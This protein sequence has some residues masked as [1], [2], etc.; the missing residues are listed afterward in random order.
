MASGGR[1]ARKVQ[2]GM[3]THTVS[4]SDATPQPRKLALKLCTTSA[5]GHV[6]VTFNETSNQHWTGFAIEG[7]AIAAMMDKRTSR[8]QGS[9][10]TTQTGKS[11][12]TTCCL[13]SRGHLRWGGLR[14]RDAAIGSPRMAR[15]NV[16]KAAARHSR[17]IV[18]AWHSDFLALSCTCSLR[19]N[20]GKQKLKEP[21]QKALRPLPVNLVLG[22][23]F[24][25]IHNHPLLLHQCRHH[26]HLL[27]FANRG[28]RYSSAPQGREAEG[29]LPGNLQDLQIQVSA[30]PDQPPLTQVS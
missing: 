25:V 24:I 20:L 1:H 8:R 19:Y 29:M 23:G 9:L 13:F 10:A 7:A 14:T 5:A 22:R 11:R 28:C 18:E 17:E 12:E 6:A 21:K 4:S 30:L 27:L 3:S 26:H 15:R 16:Q 2:H